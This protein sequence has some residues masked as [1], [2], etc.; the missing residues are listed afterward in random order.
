MR[1][2]LLVYLSFQPF[3]HASRQTISN[4]FSAA[5]E[6]LERAT[7]AHA[8]PGASAV[9]TRG[10]ETVWMDAVGR[11]TY[12]AN[13][14]PVTIQT[15]FDLA[16]LTKV[17]ATTTMAMWLQEHARLRLDSRIEELV[18]EIRRQSK[19]SRW[20]AVTVRMLLAHC[21]G[22]RGYAPLF[23]NVPD[24]QGVRQKLFRLGLDA[25]P[26]TRTEYSDLGFILLGILLER[27]AGE[28]LDTFCQREVF[29]PL[30]MKQTCFNPPLSQRREIPP[31]EDDQKYRHRV[32]QGEVH[33]Q[34]ASVLGG[35]AGHAGLFAT[36]EDVSK[37][38]RCMLRRGA[39]ILRPETVDL[40]TWRQQLPAATSRTLGWD[41]PSSPSQSGRYFGP[42]SFG[43]LGFTGTSLW[44]DPERKV[45]VT[46][47]TNRTWPDR[48]SEEIKRVRP[49]FHDT[50]VEALA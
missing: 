34:N 20:S 49:Q 45:S 27:I 30:G 1:L 37:F 40:F 44:I 33:D 32:I 26:G 50:V 3:M 25:N 43:H 6:V 4:K 41:T 9:V 29:Q 13:S 2:F 7:L 12:E 11:F 22:L 36:A 17:I 15:V 31:S 35:V 21:S 42:K 46:L 16:S 28:R 5:R 14:T 48:K 38:A 8:F 18:P 23:E 39:P 47:L 19:D 10:P 24:A